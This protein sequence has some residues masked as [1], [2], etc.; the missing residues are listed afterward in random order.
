MNTKSKEQFKYIFE[1]NQ[2]IKIQLLKKLAEHKLINNTKNTI[3][4]WNNIIIEYLNNG[5]NDEI[6]YSKLRKLFKK[7]NKFEDIERSKALAYN[8]IKFISKNIKINKLLDYGCS[9]GAITKQL[10]KILK[11]D[12]ENLYGSDIKDYNIKDFNFILLN[13]NNL[14]PQIS[15]NSIDLITCSM[16]LHHV[17]NINE[18]L[19]E[20]KRILSKKGII[21]IREHDCQTENFAVF[22]DIIHGLYS[23]V[24]S[25]PIED[26]TFIETYFANYRT[27]KEW[28]NLFLNFR[29]SMFT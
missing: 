26:E 12:N 22:L 14:M 24:W 29:F 13:N 7:E 23:L 4:D 15:N 28:I 9:S 8:I 10:G 16:V 17:E 21:I 1:N 27:R 3:E 6:I 18:T 20:F 11:I 2:N 25:D 19:I 5:D